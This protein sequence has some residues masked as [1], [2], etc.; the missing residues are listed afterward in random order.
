MEKEILE[1][2][3]KYYNYIFKG[4]LYSEYIYIAGLKN[5]EMLFHK[6]ISVRNLKSTLSKIMEN[7]IS[8]LYFT[9]NTFTNRSKK[10]SEKSMF[11]LKSIVIDVDFHGEEN[12]DIMIDNFINDIY[13]YFDSCGIPQPNIEHITG[14]GVQLYWV[15]YSVSKK[16]APLYEKVRNFL[17]NSINEYMDDY[18][19]TYN[20]CR[21]DEISSKKTAGLFRM[22]ETINNN[23]YE[24]PRTKIRFI[25]EQKYKF[26][27]LV[28]QCLISK[29]EFEKNTK[30]I[31]KAK[32]F[33][34]DMKKLSENRIKL[35]EKE[36]YNL[37]VGYRDIYM[38]LYIN[39]LVK[40]YEDDNKIMMYAEELNNHFQKPLLKRKIISI[41]KTVKKATNIKNVAGYLY[42]NK[43]FLSQL[44]IDLETAKKYGLMVKSVDKN[45]ARNKKRKEKK[46]LRN[47]AIIDLYQKKESKLSISKKVKCCFNTV[48]KIIMEFEEETEFIESIKKT[49]TTIEDFMNQIFEYGEIKYTKELINDYSD[50]YSKVIKG[51][52]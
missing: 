37:S 22:F 50:W 35:I 49:A 31:I 13:T 39:E 26:Q 45:A 20:S 46:D 8:N 25:R 47:Q 19:I 42:T 10:R 1:D 44:G 5:D 36:G 7:S 43:K 11:A 41:F 34:G 28:D 38:F 15:F 30:K 52:S 14:R 33:K 2:C 12:Y 3:I 27:E 51:Y 48:K 24:K 18:C 29:N 21:V 16:L 32:V 40:I 9:P 6:K 17:I 23:A 4:N